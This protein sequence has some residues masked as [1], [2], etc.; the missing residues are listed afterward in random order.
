LPPVISRPRRLRLTRGNGLPFW[1]F[2]SG[3][4]FPEAPRALAVVVFSQAGR[5]NSRIPLDSKQ[6]LCYHLPKGLSAFRPGPP[7][8]NGV[9]A[10][11]PPLRGAGFG[12]RQSP[13]GGGGVVLLSSD[14]SFSW[15]SG[16][17][18][19]GMDLGAFLLPG[20]HPVFLAEPEGGP[21]P[22][23][24]ILF[25]P[26]RPP[27]WLCP[28]ARE[29]DSVLSLSL[30]LPGFALGAG[31]VLEAC[32]GVKARVILRGR[33]S[34]CRALGGGGLWVLRFRSLIRLMD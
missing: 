8:K 20:L 6:A 28:S 14:I 33:V 5:G 25:R 23:A 7:R 16:A 17:P 15:A 21:E 34:A 22:F 29:A 31:G 24:H 13:R 2:A 10:G 11:G 26:G 30:E 9:W 4:C 19:A 27:S 12:G 18:G 32:R 3:A 1:A